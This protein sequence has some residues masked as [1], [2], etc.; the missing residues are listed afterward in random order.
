MSLYYRFI[1]NSQALNIF[2]RFEQIIETLLAEK[3]N[4]KT[5]Y[6]NLPWSIEIIKDQKRSK[7]YNEL[8]DIIIKL[9]E[10]RHKL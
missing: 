5:D 8:C 9:N 6:E 2:V 10:L 1:E 7:E 4:D 3:V